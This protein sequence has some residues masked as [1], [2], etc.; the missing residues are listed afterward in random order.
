V[1]P[2]KE[3]HSGNRTGRFDMANFKARNWMKH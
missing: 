3:E 1:E 2:R